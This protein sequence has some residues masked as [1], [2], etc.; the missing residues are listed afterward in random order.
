MFDKRKRRNLK[1]MIE[2]AGHLLFCL[3]FISIFFI[4]NAD[5]FLKEFNLIILIFLEAG[6]SGVSFYIVEYLIVN[7]DNQKNKNPIQFGRFLASFTVNDEPFEFEITPKD[8]KV[9]E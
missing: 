4:I 3:I 6:S 9:D 2:I 8:L 1:F 7:V 5:I